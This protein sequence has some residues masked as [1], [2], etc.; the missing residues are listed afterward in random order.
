M[1]VIFKKLKDTK[2]HFDITDVSMRVDAVV[3]DE[4]LEAFQQFLLAAGF[5]PKGE[6]MFVDDEANNE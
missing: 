1:I 3:L 6:L 5:S 2:N 4:L